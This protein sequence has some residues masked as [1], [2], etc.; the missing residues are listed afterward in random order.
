MI[1]HYKDPS[2]KMAIISWLLQL[3]GMAFCAPEVGIMTSEF[4]S[5]TQISFKHIGSSLRCDFCLFVYSIFF[6]APQNF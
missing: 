3:V 2:L 4:R 1:S 5:K 6:S